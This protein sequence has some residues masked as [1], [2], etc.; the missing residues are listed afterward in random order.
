MRKKFP[1]SRWR[2]E[3]MLDNCMLVEL[4]LRTKYGLNRKAPNLSERIAG[5]Y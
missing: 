3:V 1:L 4:I 2:K 5:A